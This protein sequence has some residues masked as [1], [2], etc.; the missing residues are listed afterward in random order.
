MRSFRGVIL[1]ILAPVA[2]LGQAA[3]SR[4]EFEVASIKAS[5][6]PGAGGQVNV[7]LR[8]DGAQVH[9]KYL[10]IKEYLGMAYSMRNYQISGPDWIASDRFD[11]D[12]KLPA[13][14]A[15]GQIPD[16]LQALLADRFELKLHRDKKEFP[17]NALVIGKGGLK[18]T[19]AKEEAGGETSDAAKAPVNVTA[20]GSRYGVTVSLGPGSYYVFA[21][22]KLDAKKLSMASLAETLTRFMDRPV[23]DMT[24]LK[25]RYDFTLEF[26][27]EDYR[28][29]T[30]RSALAAGVQLPP[31]ARQ[32]LIGVNDDSIFASIQK[33][34]LKLEPRKA[35]LDVLVVDHVRKTPT[36]N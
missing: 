4:L 8:L 25:G 27:A 2:V 11:I 9:I 19:E 3:P 5:E 34:G 28:A 29:M 33:L 7:G 35:P 23:V 16:M 17:V 30:I 18:M 22:N 24:D 36:E 12:A 15:R 10:S 1:S 14:S 20:S 32:A 13:G 6:Q 26:T 21:D 31:E